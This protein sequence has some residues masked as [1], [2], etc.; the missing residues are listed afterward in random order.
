LKVSG[1]TIAEV[2]LRDQRKC[3]SCGITA[4]PVLAIHHVVPVHLGGIDHLSNLTILCA[5]CHRIVHWLATGDRS[6]DGHSYGLG[7]SPTARSRIVRLA[8]KIRNKRIRSIGPDRRLIRSLPL[9][10]ALQSVIGRNGLTKAEA[11]KL[12]RCFTRAWKAMQPSD[13]K[14]CGIRRVRGSRFICVNPNNHLWIRV[15]AWNDERSRLDEDIL[16]I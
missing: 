6:M 12:R 1:H 10:T 9:S 7:V 11:R 16:L 14:E 15:P 3:Q 2:Y 4:R 5:N 13:R 8:Q